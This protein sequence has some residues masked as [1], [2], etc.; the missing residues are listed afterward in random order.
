MQAPPCHHCDAA[1][2][3]CAIHGLICKQSE[4][5]LHRQSSL[6][7]NIH[8]GLSAAK[9]PFHLRPAR[10]RIMVKD[11]TTLHWFLG[12]MESCWFGVTYINTFAPSYLARDTNESGA[13]A[14]TAKMRKKGNYNDNGPLTLFPTL[15]CGD[16]RGIRP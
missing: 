13:V 15:C 16:Y 4:G 5:R 3:A 2:D 9:F 8:R 11:Q 12:N 7:D 10:V 6:N 14:A 1:E